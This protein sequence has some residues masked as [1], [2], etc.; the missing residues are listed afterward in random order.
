MRV[1][2][3]VRLRCGHVGRIGNRTPAAPDDRRR[4][5]RG[6]IATGAGATAKQPA[7]QQRLRLTGLQRA[8]TLRGCGRRLTS[9]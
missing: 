2:V 8:G 3:L 6:A 7:R 4:P 5:R 9:A 1:S